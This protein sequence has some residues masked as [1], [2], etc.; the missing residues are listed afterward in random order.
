MKAVVSVHLPGRENVLINY[1]GVKGVEEG[2]K[3]GWGEVVKN[4]H[5]GFGITSK[6]KVSKQ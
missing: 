5:R 1:S 2:K 3:E 4:K 6:N